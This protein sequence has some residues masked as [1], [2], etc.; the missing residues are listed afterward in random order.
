MSGKTSVDGAYLEPIKII[1][2]IIILK[3]VNLIWFPIYT[4]YLTPVDISMLC[5][6][7]KAGIHLCAIM[8]EFRPTWQVQQCTRFAQKHFCQNIDSPFLLSRVSGEHSSPEIPKLSF[9]PHL[10]PTF[11]SNLLYIRSSTN[12]SRY[13]FFHE[14]AHQFLQFTFFGHFL[15]VYVKI[16]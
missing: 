2:I 8:K 6:Y 1:V 10:G 13:G 9:Y 15:D 14:F 12:W 4:I 3:C 7:N 5:T 16:F 11:F